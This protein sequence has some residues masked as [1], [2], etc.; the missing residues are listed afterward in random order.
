MFRARFD[1][2]ENPRN[3]N[4]V[5][6]VV[7]ESEDSVNVIALT[8]RRQVVMVQQYRFGIGAE[9][10]ELPGGLAESGEDHLRAA[11]RELR[12]ETGYSGNQWRY[13]GSIQAN[14]VYMDSQLH[15][16]LL[17]DARL[18]DPLDLDEEEDIQVKT[19]PLEEVKKMVEDGRIQHPHV[20]SALARVMP[21]WDE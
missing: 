16:F 6:V 5:K 11:R 2:L 8:S 4:T 7:L 14:P 19:L 13:L 9:T 18:T 15:H 10:L 1:Y 17:E 21:L 3:R 20:I 12:E